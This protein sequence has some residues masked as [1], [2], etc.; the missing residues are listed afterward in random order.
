MLPRVLVVLATLAALLGAPPSA[1]AAANALH[2][3]SATPTAGTT[4][5][6]FELRVHYEGRFP[7]TSVQ[8][9]VATRTV[10][11]AR[12]AGSAADG[13]WEASLQLPAGV[14]PTTF[15]A[16]AERGA[17]PVL[18]G[19]TLT[20]IGPTP[21]PVTSP[22]LA[23]PAPR[24]PGPTRDARASGDPAMATPT[25]AA[26]APAEQEPVGGPAGSPDAPT[27]PD[28]TPPPGDPAPGPQTDGGT[29]HD[30]APREEASA[31]PSTRQAPADDGPGASA[32]SNGA[33][34]DPAA[35]ASP[36]AGSILDD[37]LVGEAMRA[38]ALWLAGLLALAAVIL[39]LVAGRRRREAEEA[40]A[41]AAAAAAA[42][43]LQRRTLRRRR[44]AATGDDPIVAAMHLDD[45][46]R[47]ARAGKPRTP[48][49]RR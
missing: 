16:S 36:G 30:P 39:G 14:W 27:D 11:M 35:S 4:Q 45:G 37:P 26:G 3:A 33:P 47:G 28:A 40:E 17:S 43:I 34:R 24:P 6:T 49:R 23:T 10:S 13:R 32:D 46:P 21:Q 2:S 20:V 9:T 31:P 29:T 7:A 12:V 15:T 19:P 38:T 42:A 5:T 22:V 18:V 44:M 8:V 1:S 25:P 48:K 41:T